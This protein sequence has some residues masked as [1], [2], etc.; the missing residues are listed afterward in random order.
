[1]TPLI[2]YLLGV[3]IGFTGGVVMFI[4]TLPYI[5]ERNDA[6]RQRLADLGYTIG[7]S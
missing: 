2:A 1:M 4:V 5:V 3:G 7:G 6:L